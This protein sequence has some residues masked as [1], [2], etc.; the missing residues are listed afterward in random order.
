MAAR[1]TLVEIFEDTMN[2]IQENDALKRSV[3]KSLQGARL[4]REGDSFDLGVS[5]SGADSSECAI[6]VTHHRTFEAAQKLCAKYP[7]K[8]VAVLNFASA[9]NPGGGV[10][11]GARAQEEC[12]CRCSTLYP[13]LTK[14]E[15][16]DGYYRFHRRRSDSLYTDACI[17]VPDVEIIKSDE[18]EPR[19][20]PETDWRKVDVITCAAPNLRFDPG[21][22]SEDD[23]MELHL[24]RGERI[25]QV[26]VANHVDVLVL[27]AF[28][29]GA[30]RNN[31]VV[32]AEAYAQLLVK[33]KGRF[34]AVEF[35]VYCPPHSSENYDAF[36]KRFA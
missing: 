7:G 31:P 14:E 5:E 21:A 23:Q 22:L 19:R 3:E 32:V 2:M 33:Y 4:Y 18:D 1:D 29:C 9:T 8:R 36:S 10:T 12:L 11:S 26:A 28:G 35:A 30:F 34:S 16:I 6:M 15:F 13:V 20:L 24:K 25:F 17:Y 27:G